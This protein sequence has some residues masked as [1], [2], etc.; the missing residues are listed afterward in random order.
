MLF[1]Y[2]L[3][4]FAIIT[5]IN[6][7]FFLF[8][9]KF[10]FSK[11]HKAN[12][13]NDPV[14]VIVYIKNQEKLLNDFIPKLI[15]QNH[16]DFEL[17]LVNNASYDNTLELLEF[18]E[19]EHSN[20][21]IVDVEN[22]EA[23]WG[24]KKYAL[25]LG[26]KKASHKKLLFIT[27]SVI[28][29]SENWISETSGLLSDKNELIVGYNNFKKRKGLLSRIMRFNR[30]QSCIQNFG[31]GSYTK[32]YRAWQ[33][34]LGFS[35][36]LFFENNG[37][38]SHMNVAHETENLF[39]KEA[40]TTKNTVFATTKDATTYNQSLSFKNWFKNSK[41]RLLSVDHYTTGVKL[42]LSIFYISQLLFWIGAIAGGIIYQNSLWFALIGL[43]FVI[44]GI[45]IG[46][47]AFKLSER[48][49]FYLF[50]LWELLN[51]FIQISIFISNLFS[52]PQH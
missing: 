35:S 20:V 44:A 26:I 11:H 30:L 34:N 31:I 32:P 23:F 25:T 10:S 13:N 50:P 52:K 43:R 3:L 14:S 41:E 39:L 17:I 15:T 5:G 21:K 38:S 1:T 16:P 9:S 22:N 49:L 6:C 42:S 19:K 7:L 2:L 4:A 36:E 40:A 12:T 27:P 37:Y 8:F 51:I 33:N 24:S 48:D 28:E 47:S 29:L 45:V 46:K 18:F